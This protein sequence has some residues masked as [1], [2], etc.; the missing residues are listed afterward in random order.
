MILMTRGE[1]GFEGT[2][3][4]SSSIRFHHWPLRPIGRQGDHRHSFYVP[5]IHSMSVEMLIFR[6]Q[7]ELPFFGTKVQTSF[8]N[9]YNDG[10][11]VAFANFLITFS[12]LTRLLAT[13]R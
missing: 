6:V 13:H 4:I 5:H 7:A 10:L 12:P 3:A 11:F 8:C 1:S 9:Y 2:L